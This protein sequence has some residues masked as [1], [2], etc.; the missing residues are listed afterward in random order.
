MM[1]TSK[2]E[3]IARLLRGKLWL[4]AKADPNIVG[5]DGKTPLHLAAQEGHVEC[6]K[7]LLE[8]KAD[9]N[10]VDEDGKTPLHW[11]IAQ[12]S[13]FTN[14]KHDK[15]A[16]QLLL[17]GADAT[18]VGRDHREMAQKQKQGLTPLVAYAFF[19]RFDEMRA[20]LAKGEDPN[21]GDANGSTPLHWAAEE[22]H[23]ECVKLL[24][25]A[26]ADPNKG[27]SLGRTAAYS[28]LLCP[29]N[30][31]ENPCFN[32]LINEYHAVFLSRSAALLTDREKPI[33]AALFA[34]VGAAVGGGLFRLHS[35]WKPNQ[36]VVRHRQRCAVPAVP[37]RFFDSVSVQGAAV[38]I[39]GG[40]GAG[41]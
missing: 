36:H 1:A 11:A 13:D 29:I 39:R 35:S 6:V 27:D 9:P 21:Q 16:K 10:I 2:A 19:G 23:V 25:E 7:L 26:K 41:D 4:E 12:G 22:G 33:R 20:L 28:S 5:K 24:L 34:V 30:G 14:R 18:K 40:L 38:L 15:C 3:E 8:A 32:V 17:F 37:V 31:K